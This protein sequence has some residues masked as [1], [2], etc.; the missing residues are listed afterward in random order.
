MLFRSFLAAISIAFNLLS[1]SIAH[2]DPNYNASQLVESQTVESPY[3]YDFPVL[4]NGSLADSGRFPMP[5]CH[6]FRLE[7][8][9]IDQLQRE[10]SRGRL[11]SVQL[12]L[13]YLQRV[14]QA[15]GYIRW[16]RRGARMSI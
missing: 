2:K 3:P 12:A 8:A 16:A 14:Y 11:T 13:C 9:T 7:E 15:D 5:L 1:S 4:Q 6:G 10:L